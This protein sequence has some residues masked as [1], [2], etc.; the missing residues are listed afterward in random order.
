MEKTT[1]PTIKYSIKLF[2]K[3][4][5]GSEMRNN[6]EGICYSHKNTPWSAISSF[7]EDK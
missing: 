3:K 4:R 5:A 7:I 1:L 6:P 2:M